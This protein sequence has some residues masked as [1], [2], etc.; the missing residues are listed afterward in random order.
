MTASLLM[1]N[2]PCMK[3]EKKLIVFLA[4][5]SRKIVEACGRNREA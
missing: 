1:E 5:K 3:E 4:Q 2:Y